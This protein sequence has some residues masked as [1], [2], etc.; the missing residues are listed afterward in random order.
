M[1]IVVALSAVAVYWFISRPTILANRFVAAVE[2][3]DYKTAKSLLRNEYWFFDPAAE[4]TDSIDRIYAEV[5]PREWSDFRACQRRLILRV[6]RHEDTD[7]R[8]VDWTEDTDVVA[9]SS[10]LEI[11]QFELDLSNLKMP[12]DL[13]PTHLPVGNDYWIYNKTLVP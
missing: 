6:S 13:P 3:Q 8:H 1:F 5:L 10:G 9:S 7:G 2:R 4:F 12:V 11:K